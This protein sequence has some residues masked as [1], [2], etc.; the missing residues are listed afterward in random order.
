MRGWRRDFCTGWKASGTRDWR[1]AA[2]LILMAPVFGSA[3]VVSL[4]LAF[5]GGHLAGAAGALPAYSFPSAHATTITAIAVTG[6][7]VLVRER[8]AHWAPALTVALALIA[9]VG[10]SR[11][12]LDLSRATDVIGGWA[13]GLFIAAV[14]VTFYERLANNSLA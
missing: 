11:A 5:H 1:S 2:G 14:A 13:V 4:K 10:I 9:I 6:A 12:Y 3:I 7:D 8:V